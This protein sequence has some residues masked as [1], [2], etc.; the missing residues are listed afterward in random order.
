ECQLVKA[1][2]VLYRMMKGEIFS[3]VVPFNIIIYATY[4]IDNLGLSLKLLKRMTMMLG[5]V[6][7]PNYIIYDCKINEFC[8]NEKLLFAEEML[9][10]M[11]KASKESSVQIYATLINRY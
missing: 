8:K 11:V 10:K 4:R 3:N 6:I 7:W 1:I 5:D 2:S 9:R